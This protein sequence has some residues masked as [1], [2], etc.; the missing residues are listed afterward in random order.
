VLVIEDYLRHPSTLSI[1]DGFVIN[2]SNGR[3]GNK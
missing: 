1:K 2:A 3:P